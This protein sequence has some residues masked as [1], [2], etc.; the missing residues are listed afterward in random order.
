M[1]KIIVLDP[2]HGG[3]DPGALGPN[4][5]RESTVALQI[6]KRAKLKIEA[7]AGGLVEVVL[8]RTD[9]KTYPTLQARPAIANHLKASAFV[10]VH[11]N[12]AASYSANGFELYT[13]LGENRSD[14][15][16]TA[17]FKRHEARFPDQ[18]MRT[19]TSDGDPDKEASFAVIRG[20]DCPSVLVEEEFIHNLD[21]EAILTSP[22][23]QSLMAEAL[24]L[25]I[26][27]FLDLGKI[28]LPESPPAAPERT[29]E[30]RLESMKM[31][32]ATLVSA[33]PHQLGMD[34]SKELIAELS[35]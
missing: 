34:L 20:T 11:C 3:H 22:K 24:A 5:T 28:P 32:L 9:D 23:V 16:A 6:C 7:L 2:G 31:I 33:L 25:G 14:D 19:D 27:D 17:I 18:K 4:G 8:T 30:E 12:S 26:L 21:G 13:T 29:V 10:S 1:K 35:K 15:L